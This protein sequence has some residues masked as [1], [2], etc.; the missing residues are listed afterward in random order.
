MA[1]TRN[2]LDNL[3]SPQAIRQR[4]ADLD[5]ERSALLVIL[6]ATDLHGDKKANAQRC[7]DHK[8]RKAAANA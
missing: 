3:P 1:R 6:K 7:Q 8:Q 4:L 5:H 2:L